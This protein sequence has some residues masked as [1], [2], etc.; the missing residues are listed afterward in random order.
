MRVEVI[1]L[2]HVLVGMIC[3]LVIP[4]SEVAHGRLL[5]LLMGYSPSE[6]VSLVCGGGDMLNSS[7]SFFRA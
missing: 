7:A 4:H 3:H 2:V 1:I 6:V 5:G